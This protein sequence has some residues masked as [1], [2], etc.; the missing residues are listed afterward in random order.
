MTADHLFSDL[1]DQIGRALDQPDTD[2]AILRDLLRAARA[3]LAHAAVEARTLQDER[4]LLR[5]LI[6]FIPRTSIY[7]KDLDGR[8]VFANQ[9]DLQVMGMAHLD[10]VLGKRDHDIYPADV[11]AQSDAD[12][13]MVMDGRQSLI[14]REELL[15]DQHGKETWW[16][17][18]K[19]PLFDRNGKLIGLI[20][21]GH[22]IT[23]RRKIEDQLRQS[24]MEYKALFDAALRQ[25]QELTLL[26]QVRTILAREI[27]LAT[28]VRTVCE[29]IAQ[30]FGYTHISIF[31]LEGAELV[32]QH[33]I[34]YTNVT[35]RVSITTGI[36][37][38]VVRT[39]K[40]VLVED[41]DSDPDFLSTVNGLGSEICVPLRDNERV[42]GTLNIEALSGGKA[43]THADLDLMIA[44]SEHVSVA[45]NR[46]RLVDD[47]RASEAQMRA[48]LDAIPDMIVRFN[49]EGRHLFIKRPLYFGSQELMER[50]LGRTLSETVPD[51][52][53]DTLMS[54]IRAALALNA[55]QVVEYQMTQPDG[56]LLDF[57]ARMVVAG[58]D[59]VL[60]IIR[61]ITDQKNAER[62]RQESER[63]RILKALF[64]DISHDL[65]TPIATMVTSIYLIQKQMDRLLQHGN[66]LNARLGG[67]DHPFAALAIPTLNEILHAGSRV[68]DQ[69]QSLDESAL[70]LRRMVESMVDMSRLDG[71]LTYPFQLE[72]MSRI[73]QREIHLMQSIAVEKGVSLTYRA[74]DLPPMVNLN[75]AE[76]SR[77]LQ[78]LVGNAIHYT[79]SGGTVTVDL[80]IDAR[81]AIVDVRDTGIGIE[82]EEIALIFNRLYRADKARGARGGGMGLGLAI[83]K[84]IVDAHGGDISVESRVGVGS[85]FRVRLPLP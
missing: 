70:R 53:A 12:D 6:D 7:I 72:D 18:N 23:V 64:D 46:A 63:M 16:L 57:E 56:A 73:V 83:C 21:T 24:E 36:S 76:F 25:A 61:D 1:H 45:I 71:T 50:A 78:N 22:D 59:E 19:Q 2:P 44:L 80:Y 31:L 62:N 84:K 67:L 65:R 40:P 69:T 4:D 17:T 27:D 49:R 42:V 68:R 30:T 58:R 10:E 13:R 82:P 38:R 79:A 75:D 74:P 54:G 52:I 43:L 66:L 9:T 47:V 81:D 14:D 15:I 77:V 5:M 51:T 28:L 55:M 3:E 34:G 8:K 20:G 32:L 35:P 48:L 29:A 41:A 60:A 39:G 37:G 33:Q 85:T 26:D 11:A